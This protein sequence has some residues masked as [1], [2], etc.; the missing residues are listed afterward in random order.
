MTTTTELA[1]GT[2]IPPA[3]NVAKLPR[4]RECLEA[5]KLKVRSAWRDVRYAYQFRAERLAWVPGQIVDERPL[6][7]DL[8][9]LLRE[10]ADHCVSIRKIDLKR[11]VIS[12]RQYEETIAGCEAEM[13]RRNPDAETFCAPDFDPGMG[14]ALVDDEWLPTLA[15]AIDDYWQTI[16]FA[17]H[18][19]TARVLARMKYVHQEI[20]RRLC[21]RL[22]ANRKVGEAVAA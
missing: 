13:R 17:H 14:I 9:E 16:P 5:A 3:Y 1:A 19:I 21:E 15:L 4:Y 22:R 8:I 12:A 2:Y 11:A 18:G 6:T 20:G 7:A 10:H